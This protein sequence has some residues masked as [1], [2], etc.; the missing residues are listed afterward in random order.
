[1]DTPPDILEQ[2]IFAPIDDGAA[3][4][5]IKLES[6]EGLS[7]DEHIAWTFFLGSL[8]TRQPDVLEFLKAHGMSRLKRALAEGDAATLPRGCPTTEEWFARNYPGVIEAAPLTSWLPKMIFSEPVLDAFGVSNG[9][10][11]GPL[12]GR[13]RSIEWCAF[14]PACGVGRA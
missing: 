12:G 14:R 13:C 7:E 8:R 11:K 3:K 5:L 10:Q 6:H 1:M 2:R 9:V 4:V